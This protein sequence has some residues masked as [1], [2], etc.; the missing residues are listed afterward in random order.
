[1]FEFIEIKIIF[2]KYQLGWLFKICIV[3]CI[4]VFLQHQSNLRR[5]LREVHKIINAT[6]EMFK[7]V[8][9]NKVGH[10][11]IIHK[12]LHIAIQNY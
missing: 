4:K 10:V 1:M 5:H 2:Q 7:C 6:S 9:C 8:A 11:I 3:D 12:S